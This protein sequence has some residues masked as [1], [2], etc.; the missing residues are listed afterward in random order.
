MMTAL[1]MARRNTPAKSGRKEWG[2]LFAKEKKAI[3]AESVYKKAN[4][5]IKKVDQLKASL[6]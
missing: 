4:S 6:K 3:E 2:A 1:E 5:V